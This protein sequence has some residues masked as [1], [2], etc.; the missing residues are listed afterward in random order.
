VAPRHRSL[1]V[2]ERELI[3]LVHAIRHWRPY[4]WGRH[5]TVC[6]DHYSLKFLLDQRL[7]TIPQHHWVRKLLGFDFTVEYKPGA[8]NMVAGTLSRRDTEDGAVLAV[9]APCFDYIDR[10]RQ[11]PATDPALVALRDELTAGSRGAPWA[12]TDDLV[13]YDGRLY[14]PPASPLLPELLAAVHEDGHEGVQRTLHRLRRDFHFPD[15]RRIVQ[16]FV[17][18]CATCQRYKS[19]H[20]H[21]AGLLL[22]LPVP[23]AVWAD[24]GLDFVEA[25]P[26]VRG[27]S[28]ILTVVDRFSKYC[29]FIPLAHPYSAESVAQA[30]FTDLMRLHGMP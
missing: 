6:T 18:A 26:R 4:L 23:T 3:G 19:E 13:T 12:L 2:Y 10:L 24:I 7:A 9:S 1:A 11:A 20:L 8:L 29:H 30:F 16:D 28:V 15:M 17:H 27:K 14:V 22:P 5:F 21:P 25:L